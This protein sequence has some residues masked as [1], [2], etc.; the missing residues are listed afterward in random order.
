MPEGT[1]GGK[2]EESASHQIT[3]KLSVVFGHLVPWVF[4]LQTDRIGTGLEKYDGK[5]H[6]LLKKINI[7]IERQYSEP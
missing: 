4:G 1:P 7:Q 6:V 2:M 5:Y 3:L